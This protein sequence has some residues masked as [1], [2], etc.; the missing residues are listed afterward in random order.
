MLA[1]EPRVRVARRAGSKSKSQDP[2]RWIQAS[3]I[4][5]EVARQLVDSDF[6]F[7]AADSHLRGMI[8]NAVST[9][10]PFPRSSKGRNRRRARRS[11]EKSEDMSAYCPGSEVPP[12][13]LTHLSHKLRK[14]GTKKGEGT[15]QNTIHR[16]SCA[17]RHHL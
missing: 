17:E 12:V 5:P 13:Q 2:L 14:K 7:L 15:N 6:I 1:L 3:V 11:P 9:N 16:R 4:E 8:V 10:V